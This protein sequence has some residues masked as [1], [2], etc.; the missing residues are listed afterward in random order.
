MLSSILASARRQ[1]KNQLDVLIELLVS[2]D[3]S[4]IL[5]LVPPTRGAAARTEQT[6]VRELLACYAQPTAVGSVPIPVQP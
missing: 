4:K 5:A 3:K 1:G 6:V 2:K